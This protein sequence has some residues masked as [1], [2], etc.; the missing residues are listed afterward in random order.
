MQI[1]TGYY[2]LAQRYADEGYALVG[3]SRMTPWFITRYP[4]FYQ[5][6]EFA[7]SEDILKLR[8]DPIEYTKR[9]EKEV[10]AKLDPMKVFEK[11]SN[12][13]RKANTDKVILLC[14]EAPDKFCHRHLV[15]EWLMKKF[16]MR[17]EEFGVSKAM[18]QPTLFDCD[19]STI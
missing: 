19:S 4:F 6:K 2:A 16:G 12:L 11:L 1:A 18:P 5:L 3:I 15:A 7:P 10:L 17:I 8:D 14:Y 13:A 9:Y